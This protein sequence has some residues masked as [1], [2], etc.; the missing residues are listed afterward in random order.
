RLKRTP[1]RRQG[2][3]GASHAFAGR[4]LFS[5]LPL[6]V[7]ARPQVRLQTIQSILLHPTRTEPGR[8]GR[9]VKVDFQPMDWAKALTARARKDPPGKG[10]WNILHTLLPGSDVMNPA[11]NFGLTGAWFGWPE[12]APASDPRSSAGTTT[13]SRRE[14]ARASG[15]GRRAGGPRRG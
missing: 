10:D 6:V 11:V 2:I 4:P 1:R 7:A 9:Y 15:S 8:S 13:R 12:G 3:P 5:A 14:R